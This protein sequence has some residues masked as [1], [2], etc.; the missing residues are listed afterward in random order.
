MIHRP[1]DAV[2]PRQGFQEIKGRLNRAEIEQRGEQEGTRP[3]L[4]PVL[5][6]P[7]DGLASRLLLPD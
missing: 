6:S 3:L 5:M 1:S 2:L 7:R 4:R